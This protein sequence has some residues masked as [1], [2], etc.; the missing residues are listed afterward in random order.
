M[1]TMDATF[2]LLSI[3][4][5]ILS[6][7]IALVVL[8]YVIQAAIVAAMKRVRR[9]AWTEQHMPEKAT[10]LTQRQRDEL[11]ARLNQ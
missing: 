2:T 1:P 9:E 11:S 3:I 8:Y 10:W 5:P 6:W 4:L 7:A